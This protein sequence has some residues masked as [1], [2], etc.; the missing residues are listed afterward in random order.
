[1]RLR[2]NLQYQVPGTY[3]YVPGTIL[4]L[5]VT[6]AT[7]YSYQV[8]ASTY[9]DDLI[10][11][12]HSKFR[13]QNEELSVVFYTIALVVAFVILSP[14]Q[15]KPHIFNFCNASEGKISFSIQ[16]P[17]YFFTVSKIRRIILACFAKSYVLLQNG[18]NPDISYFTSEVLLCTCKRE[19]LK[20]T[21][22]FLYL[23]S[24]KV[25]T[26]NTS[27]VLFISRVISSSFI[28]P[29]TPLPSYR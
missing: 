15:K 11:L 19:R 17:R 8:L 29:T 12:V 24:Q 21:I 23:H 5:P 18:G 3:K 26:I 25:S 2:T 1:M 28:L 9:V 10:I 13:L 7:W 16:L 6:V 20:E 4:L 22:Y 27:S 14:Q